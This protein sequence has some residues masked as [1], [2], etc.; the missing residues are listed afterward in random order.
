ML[1]TLNRHFS[2]LLIGNKTGF[3]RLGHILECTQDVCLNVVCEMPMVES[4]CSVKTTFSFV[5][6][7]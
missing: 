4:V 1:N 7:S 5:E 6:G 3:P 2:I